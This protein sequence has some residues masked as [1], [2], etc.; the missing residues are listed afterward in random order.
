MKKILK[1]LLVVIVWLLI[2]IASVVV[3][4]L[5]TGEYRSG[6]WFA[7]SLFVL[8]LAFLVIR[9]LIIR[10][11]AKKR[12]ENLVNVE[13][14]EGDKKLP[15]FIFNLLS[16]RSKFSLAEQFHNLIKL[17]NKSD[18]K[19]HGDPLYVLPWY[20]MLEDEKSAASRILE[21][22]H[23]PAPVFDVDLQTTT[24]SVFVPYNQAIMIN[25]SEDFVTADTPEAREERSQL[26][27]LLQKY[28]NREP[29]N[30]IVIAKDLRSLLQS[31]SVELQE[32][33]KLIRAR[34]DEVMRGL[35]ISIPVYLMVTNSESLGGFPE[36]AQLI[37]DHAINQPM[38]YAQANSDLEADQLI[39]E[40]MQAIV[41][42][43][44]DFMIESI[45][46]HG[47]DARLLRLPTRFEKL[48]S[49]LQAF[50]KGA[51]ESNPYQESIQLK[52]IYLTANKTV[53]NKTGEDEVRGLFSHK[54]FTDIL[55][56][57]RKSTR[58]NSSHYS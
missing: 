50:A 31:D 9:R 3:S 19:R 45:N 18:L 40:A 49:S 54:F 48:E 32:E 57:D 22:A 29:L 28:R 8:W 12:V 20:L 35:K 26:I 23:L 51:F 11:N 4:V 16:S 10:H 2:A 53:T 5:L 46:S 47:A 17:L 55:P 37:P 52:G 58:L 36:W 30:G 33:G 1:F 7:G 39:S 24:G 27:Q 15:K 38:G 14:P 41:N 25:T 42:R 21:K 13:K 34:I 56:R 6:L 44:K 43:I